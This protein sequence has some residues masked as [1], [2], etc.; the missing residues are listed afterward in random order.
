M[1]Q[2]ANDPISMAAYSYAISV[3]QMMGEKSPP[4]EVLYDEA[5]KQIARMEP[6]DAV[7]ELLVAQMLMTHARILFVNRFAN[8]QKN[9]KWS[10]LMH[11]VADRAANTFGR[12]MDALAKHRTP[13]RYR[14][15]SITTIRTAHIDANQI[16]PSA[17]PSILQP[18]GDPAE[19][20]TQSNH[21]AKAAIAAA[22]QKDQTVVEGQGEKNVFG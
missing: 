18:P 11:T 13:R 19:A 7:E 10:A 14:R 1:D 12:Q 20:Q 3:R 4:K 2:P 22:D 8:K 15:A 9:L 21:P 5:L 16:T 17:Q 6:R